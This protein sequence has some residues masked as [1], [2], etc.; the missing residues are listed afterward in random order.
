VTLREVE[1][2]DLELLLAWRSNKLVHRHFT[3]Q[4][5]P[6]KWYEHWKWWKSREHRKDWV[7]LLT[8][9]TGVRRVGVA[10][11]GK[12]DREVP[13]IGLYIGEVTLWGGG[14]GRRAVQEVMNWLRREGYSR[15]MAGVRQGNER[16]VKLFTGLGFQQV[17][18][19]E[20][21]R[22]IYETDLA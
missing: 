18:V 6:L 2:D 7:V 14:V 16:S 4:H 3:D 21:G 15:C 10:N 5:G 8:D 12:L 1:E 9:E 19:T 11:V 17:S 22:R 20:G 13:E